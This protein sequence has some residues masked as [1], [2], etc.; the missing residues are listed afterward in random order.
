M[1]CVEKPEIAEVC[2]NSEE[3]EQ[4]KYLSVFNKDIS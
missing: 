4:I 1:Y 2:V 3:E